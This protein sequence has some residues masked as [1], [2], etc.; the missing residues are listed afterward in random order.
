MDCKETKAL[1]SPYLD[2]RI[3]RE[4][5]DGVENHLYGCHSCREE[6][7]GLERVLLFL[8]DQEPLPA[9]SWL[10]H[11][12]MEEVHKQRRAATRGRRAVLY[13]VW[14]LASALGLALIGQG[15]LTVYQAVA[16][17]GDLVAQ[18]SDGSAIG[19][20]LSVTAADLADTMFIIM[21]NLES[22]L[23]LG[24]SMVFVSSCLALITLM[25]YRPARTA[26]R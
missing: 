9:P 20:G 2:G 10:T 24:L 8:E 17:S 25:N 19:A 15:G 26:Y 16:Q 6:Y 7:L 12:V 11:R 4:D 14:A 1:F 22:S 5:K 18:S 13:G 23:I 21:A 3:S